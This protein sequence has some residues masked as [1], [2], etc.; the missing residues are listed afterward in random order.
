MIPKSMPW[1]VTAFCT[2]EHSCL[3]YPW[4]W[5]IRIH[6]A[7][8]INIC[9]PLFCSL[10]LPGGGFAATTRVCNQGTRSID[11]H[12]LGRKKPT[13]PRR[14]KPEEEAEGEWT[15]C[16]NSFLCGTSQ[17]HMTLF[18]IVSPNISLNFL[19]GRTHLPPYRTCWSNW[20]PP[21][22]AAKFE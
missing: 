10:Y 4:L 11:W 2:Y 7:P 8:G 14:G 19:F 5:F 15:N 13:G 20:T 3:S 22:K 17:H 16:D 18:F 9:L 1:L 6:C 21:G 12:L